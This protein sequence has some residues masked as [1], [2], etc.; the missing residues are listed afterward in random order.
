MNRQLIS[1]VAPA[2]P[3]TRRF[4]SGKEPFLRPEIGFTPKWYRAVL[5]IDFGSQW[6]LDVNYRRE[7]ILAMRHEI[8]K[9]FPDTTIGQINE[10]D[11][12]M[13]LLTGVFGACTVAALFGIPVVYSSDNWPNCEHQY[14]KDEQIEALTVPDL[15]SNNF[16]QTLLSQVDAIARLEGTVRGAIN[17]QGVLNNA[18]R[19]RGERLFLDLFDRP[20]QT[21]R[22]FQIVCDTMMAAAI[23]LY[24]KQA[25]T[26]FSPGFFTVSNCSVNMISPEQYIKFILPNDRRLAETFGCIGVHNCAWNAN[27]YLEHYAILPNLAYIDMGLESDL[28]KAKCLF[29]NARRA[30]MYTPM[31]LANKDIQSIKDDIQRIAQEYAPCDIVLADIESDTPDERIREFIRECE[32]ASKHYA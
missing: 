4:A 25:K 24:E 22:L 20:S 26:G 31:D 19:L 12:P 11:H 18:L 21:Q 27:P 13:D 23:Q 16:F 8:R 5:G 7:S 15:N 9:R 1:Y 30:L 2:A 14:L 28:V 29:P 32:A 6:H 3:A 10:P 17:W